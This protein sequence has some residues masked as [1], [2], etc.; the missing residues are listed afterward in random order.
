M[1]SYDLIDYISNSEKKTPVKFYIQGN[2]LKEDLSDYDYFGDDTSGVVFCDYKEVE[3]IKNKLGD[4]LSKERIEMDRKNSAIPLADYSKYNARIEP[5]VY[6]RDQV[7]I[8]DGCVIMMGAVI[9]IGAKIGENTMIDMNTVLGGRATVGNN[10]HIGAGTVLAGVIEPP[11]ADP[12][13]VEDDVLIGAN[14]V[15][16]EG[17]KIG[18]G[19]VIAAGS[20]V[21]DDV[22]AGSVYAGAPA[23]KIKDVDDKTKQKTEVVASLRKL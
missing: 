20:I 21:I 1:N 11:S 14:A 8:G 7:E 9:N 4:K 22:P 23:K 19:A 3:A 16:L 18:R 10:C 6:I 13:I 5:G 12:V 17:V 2:E 15:V